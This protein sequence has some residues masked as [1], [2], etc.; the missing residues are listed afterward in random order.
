[1]LVEEF[2]PGPEVTIGVAGNGSDVRVLGMMEVAPA[3][4]NGPFVYSLEMKRGWEHRVRYHQPPRLPMETISLIE[5]HALTAY[6]LLGC[7]D[8]ARLDF[9]LDAQ[10]LPHFLECNP[11]PSLHPSS[12]DIVILS[13][14]KVAYGELIRGVLNAAILREGRCLRGHGGTRARRPLHAIK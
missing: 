4:Q 12:G 6:R 2:L 13:R 7:R 3:H 14:P 10:G 11:L 9:R 1:V 5:R 8:L